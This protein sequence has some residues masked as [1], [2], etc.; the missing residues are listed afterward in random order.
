M[1]N[2]ISYYDLIKDRR[3]FRN[4]GTRS[5][6]EFNY[7]DTPGLKFFKLFFYFNN[8]DSEGT[9]DAISSGGLL[10]PT[11]L[12]DPKEEDW[13]QYNSAWSYLKMN[14]EDE[15]AEMLKNFITLLS[16]INS[17]SPW[18][19]TEISGLD[20]AIERSNIME[21]DFKIE[22]TRR[23]ISIKCLHDSFDDRI[24]TLLELYRSA[25]WSW[26]KKQEIIPANLRKF[27]MGILVYEMP[28][29]PFH[30]EVK[31]WDGIHYEGTNIFNEFNN[32]DNTGEYNEF[33]EWEPNNGLDEYYSQIGVD[34]ASGYKSSYKYF[35]FHNCEIDYSSAKGNF[36]AISNADGIQPEY[37]IDILFDDCYETRYNEFSFKTF[38]D[39]VAT[40]M[41]NLFESSPESSADSSLL[42]KLS[43]K[44]EAWG[45][46][47]Y[48]KVESNDLQNET[49][50]SDDDKY[51]DEYNDEW[52]EWESKG[53]WVGQRLP[54]FP[55]KKIYDKGMLLNAVGQVVG[56]G[57]NAVV[58]LAKKAMLGN[59]YTF[60]LTRMV[61]QA[62]SAL[63]GNVWSATR[64]VMEYINDDKQRKEAGL[65]EW[66]S[67]FVKQD[68]K[69]QTTNKIGKMQSNPMIKPRVKRMGNMHK[70]NTLV[71]NI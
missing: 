34:K 10:A 35:E 13:W 65:P 41:D 22:D 16:N 59:L 50:L 37:N 28:N 27:D 67:L 11:W 14:C 19:F 38:G 70:A 62:K 23:K 20:T 47:T 30:I 61:G 60:S 9:S 52:G 18:Y 3:N 53:R 68:Y 51:D 71:N 48:S 46:N 64:N 31:D 57:V 69:F 45:K 43:K 25:V 54:G 17:E 5:G 15:R 44:S 39:V 32:F 6:G 29:N 58:S 66:H 8:G 12:L 4:S 33:G 49:I 42:E 40:D 56:T 1:S 24:A 21:R 36:S 63:Q 55:R 2:L 26:I 7:Y